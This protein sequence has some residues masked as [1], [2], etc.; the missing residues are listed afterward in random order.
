MEGNVNNVEEY[1]IPY[2]QYSRL[3]PAYHVLY[4]FCTV[5]FIGLFFLF[6]KEKGI[7]A[8]FFK[9]FSITFFLLFLSMWIF[10]GI[11]RKA[12]V[13]LT[14][15][16]IKIRSFFKTSIINWKDIFDIGVYKQGY[17]TMFGII[18]KAKAKKRKD[19]FLTLLN[20]LFAG[21]YSAAIA[22]GLYPDVD[23]ERFYFTITNKV[24]EASNTPDGDLQSDVKSYEVSEEEQ[25][26]SFIMALI[27]CFFVSFG[28]GTLYGISLYVFKTNVILIPLLIYIAIIYVYH[29]NYKEQKV[30]FIFRILIGFVCAAHVFVGVILLFFLSTKMHFNVKNLIDAIKELYKY[31]LHNP[32][33]EGRI[34]FTAAFVF[35][36]GTFQGYKFKVQK[37]LGKLMMKKHGSYYYKKDGKV[38][39]VYLID[40]AVHNEQN[41]ENLAAV[42]HKDCLIDITKKK[43]NAFYIPV[44]VIEE[45]GC[46]VSCNRIV[47]I[48]NRSYYKLDFGST[49]NFQNYVFPC[50]VICNKE[51]HIE[52]L[53]IQLK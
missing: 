53:E 52:A 4:L 22:L 19:Y 17:N 35:L 24:I 12:Y 38:V 6:I 10:L 50:V 16:A 49:G 31:Y 11:I 45:L 2:K 15:D 51:K 39:T 25:K 47:E 3:K 14:E 48:D 8:I 32:F 27:K 28:A 18:T 46:R 44:S 40:P 5:L 42:I 29:K 21:P 30:N 41:T 43:L 33:D 20:D 34:V 1:S 26:G 9:I 23:V 7:E 36:F 37:Q 13:E